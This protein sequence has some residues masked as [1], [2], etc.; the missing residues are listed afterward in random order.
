MDV[1]IN[2]VKEL[3]GDQGITQQELAD[4]IGVTRGQI[5]HYLKSRR[6]PPIQKLKLMAQALGVSLEDLCKR[7]LLKEKVNYSK[8]FYYLPVIDWASAGTGAIPSESHEDV[9]RIAVPKKVCSKDGYILIVRGDSMTSSLYGQRSFYPEEKIIVDPDKKP[10]NGSYV[11]AIINECGEAIFK[12]F[13]QDGPMGYLKPL[14]A[15]YPILKFTTDMKIIGVV[16]GSINYEQI[17]N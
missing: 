10:I 14:N 15:Q 5:N 13:V 9:E 12:Q 17:D 8:E 1:W 3:M 4:K 7:D 2:R 16:V 6:Q 11:I